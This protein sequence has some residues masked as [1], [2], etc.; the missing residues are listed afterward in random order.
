MYSF[1]AYLYFDSTTFPLNPFLTSLF[2]VCVYVC[3][4][5]MVCHGARVGKSG[6][7]ESVLFCRV[8]SR[9]RTEVLSLAASTFTH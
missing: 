3:V 5:L 9:D 4:T 6:Q 1:T 2:N 7:F 8:G